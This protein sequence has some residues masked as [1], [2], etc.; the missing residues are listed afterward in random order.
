[1]GK[2]SVNTAVIQKVFLAQRATSQV[3]KSQ[4]IANR[5]ARLKKIQAWI[6][7][8]RSQIQE[9]LYLD[10]GKPAEEVDLSEIYVV[11]SEIKH[12]LKN[13]E[14]WAKPKK[15]SSNVPLIGSKSYIHYEPKGVCLIISPW[16]FPF[17]LSVGPLVSALAAGNTAILKPSELSTHCS[18]MVSEMVSELFDSDE[19]AVFNGDKQVATQLLDQPF[20]HI[21]FTGSPAVGK[22]I[23]QSAASHLTSITLELGGKSPAIIDANADLTDAAEK[24]AWG[25]FLNCGQTC[26]APDYLLVHESIEEELTDLLC[27]CIDKFFDPDWDGIENS[28]SYARIIGESHF[29]RLEWLLNDA[30]NAGAKIEYGGFTDKQSKYFS[31]T[32]LSGVPAKTGVLEKEIFGPILPILTYSEPQQAIELINSMPKPLAM[33]IFSEEKNFQK[34]V[35]NHTSAGSAA[36]NDCV[37]QFMNPYLPFGGVGESGF[38]RSHG[39]HGFLAF[40][41]QK[42]VLVQ[43][44]G[45]TSV[46]PLFPPYDQFTKKAIDMLLKYL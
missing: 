36:I 28:E 2:M 38:G 4:P 17:N 15:V 19:V 41:N 21:F 3:W 9:A 7:N 44:T 27:Q 13:L 29:E 40:S 23:M 11:L 43:K 39:H 5:V 26:I 31:P 18:A 20:D 46:K 6:E 10:S 14:H 45:L 16:N 12:A 32:L 1:M 34:M 33:Y 37:V 35:L 25:K 22:I 24:L 42:S 30:I 8:H